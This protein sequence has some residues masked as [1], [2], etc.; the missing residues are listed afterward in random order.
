MNSGDEKTLLDLPEL[1]Q[2][3]AF[4]DCG[5]LSKAAEK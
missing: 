2:L 5:R 4:A 1:E 3:V